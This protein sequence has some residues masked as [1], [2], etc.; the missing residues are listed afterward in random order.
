MS[1]V[2][3]SNPVRLMR[4]HIFLAV[5]YFLI[6]VLM[7]LLIVAQLKTYL[8][9]LVAVCLIFFLHLVLAVGS[10]RRYEWSRKTSEIVG[11]IMFLGVPV[12]T[13][14]GYLLLQ[15]TMWKNSN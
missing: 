10:Y 9:Y 15:R 12:G 4:F 13:I 3:S 2:Y 6:A 5:L 7:S 14:L 11:V 1:T 8:P